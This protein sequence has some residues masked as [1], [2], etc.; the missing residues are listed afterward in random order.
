MQ[1][2]S[3]HYTDYIVQSSAANSLR[4]IIVFF[5]SL[6]NRLCCSG[7]WKWTNYWR[8]KERKKTSCFRRAALSPSTTVKALWLLKGSHGYGY[9]TLLHNSGLHFQQ[10]CGELPLSTPT[11]GFIVGDFFEMAVLDLKGAAESNHMK[12]DLNSLPSN[13]TWKA[14]MRTRNPSH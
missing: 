2:G 7:G 9:S 11:I 14:W 12:R 6:W 5:L 3:I 8:N 10:Q 13:W 4:F 1:K